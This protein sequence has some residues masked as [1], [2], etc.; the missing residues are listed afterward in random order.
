MTDTKAL[1]AVVGVYRERATAAAANT[2]IYSVSIDPNE[3]LA[4]LDHIEALEAKAALLGACVRQDQEVERLRRVAEAARDA[5]SHLS[6]AADRLESA[7]GV[8]TNEVVVERACEDI[9]EARHAL[10]TALKETP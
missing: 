8:C 6:A 2:P 4:V 10:R 3:L 7:G 9:D 5:E 1:R